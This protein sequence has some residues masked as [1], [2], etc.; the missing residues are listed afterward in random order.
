MV[1]DLPRLLPLHR[2]LHLG[3]PPLPRAPRGPDRPH[4][5]RGRP[6]PP[7]DSGQLLPPPRPVQAAERT[8]RSKEVQGPPR[9]ALRPGRLPALT[10]SSRS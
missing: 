9:R 10:T 1:D 8:W 6:V 4:R 5:P 2:D 3:P 7:R